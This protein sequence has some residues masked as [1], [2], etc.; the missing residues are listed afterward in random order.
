M[1]KISRRSFVASA[2]MLAAALPLGASAFNFV[3]SK[4][5]G[6]HFML[7]GDIHY[8]KLYH[9][10]MDYV[11]M[12]YPNDISQIINY[13]LVTEQYLPTLMEVVRKKGRVNKSD[14]YIQLGDFVEGLCGSK[15]LAELQTTEFIEYIKD[16]KLRRPFF[17]VKGNHDITGEGA[18]EVY[19]E[20]RSEE[21][22]SEL[23][24]R[25]NL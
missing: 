18:R 10:D 17:V 13:S 14:F 24:S 16:Q 25:E 11:K 15:E 2:G 1:K 21:H 8:D 4:G 5:K 22:T 9:H 19:D 23:Q 12:R 7:L 3:P 20:T 6:Y